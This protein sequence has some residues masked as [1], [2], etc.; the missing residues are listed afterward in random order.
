MGSMSMGSSSCNR[1]VEVHAFNRKTGRVV[2]N[3][4]VSIAIYNVRTRKSMQVP[5]ML[6]VGATTGP[7]DLHYGNNV[8]A[9]AGRYTVTIL[10]NR[11]RTTFSFRLA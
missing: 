7:S 2:T 3:A 1:H 9:G 8:F 10:I 4:H 6:M 5:I 11:V